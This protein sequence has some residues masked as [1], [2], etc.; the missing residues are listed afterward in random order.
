[1]TVVEAATFEM[2]YE[3]MAL[4]RQVL[5]SA[6]ATRAYLLGAQLHLPSSS[7]AAGTRAV[8]WALTLTRCLRSEAPR[9]VRLEA[10]RLMCA[11][12][13]GAEDV[14]GSAPLDTPVAAAATA[15]AGEVR[16]EASRRPAGGS[17]CPAFALRRDSPPREGA[18][19]E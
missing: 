7:P 18:A 14:N 6:P 16:P 15:A 2:R 8:P 17:R 1:M 19:K 10:C 13:D 9:A 11:L 4:W 5:R 3:A 12:C